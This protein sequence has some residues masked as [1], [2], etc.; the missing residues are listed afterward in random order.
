M[1]RKQPLSKHHC[2]PLIAS[3]K[4][5]SSGYLMAFLMTVLIAGGERALPR[6]GGPW[7][8]NTLWLQLGRFTGECLRP[9]VLHAPELPL[10]WKSGLHYKVDKYLQLLSGKRAGRKLKPS[11]PRRLG[12]FVMLILLSFPGASLAQ[13]ERLVPL[14]AHFSR[15][16]MLLRTRWQGSENLRGRAC[17]DNQAL[18]LGHQKE[19]LCLGCVM[20]PN[21]WALAVSSPRGMYSPGPPL[22]LQQVAEYLRKHPALIHLSSMF[23]F[24]TCTFFPSLLAS[25]ARGWG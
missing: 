21:A 3:I 4:E 2:A 17:K 20:G 15:T 7:C 24:W 22:V 6:P 13:A 14:L 23:N 16:R 18:L 19:P 8:N 12:K 5:M 10:G 9:S 11:T 25:M 1:A